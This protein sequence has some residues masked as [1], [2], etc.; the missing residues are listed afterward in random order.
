MSEISDSL[1][2]RP[3]VHWICSGAYLQGP[4]QLGERVTFIPL[5]P[6]GFEAPARL[7]AAYAAD[8]GAEVDSPGLTSLIEQGSQANPSVSIIVPVIHWE[9]PEEAELS[10]AD[11]IEK[12]RE[13]LSWA[14]GN[15]VNPIGCVTLG[16]DENQSFFRAIPSETIRRRRLGFGNTDSDFDSSLESIL[17]MSEGDE[18]VAFALSMLHDANKEKNVRFKIARYYTCLESLTYKIRKGQGSR[19]AV[20][21]LLGIEKGQTGQMKTSERTYNY[22]VVLG[23]GIL[24]DMLFHG[25]PVD[26]SKARDH[27]K[28]T[29][30]LLLDNPEVISSDLQNRVEL[31][32][33]RWSNG[34]SNG[35]VTAS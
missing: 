20:R 29:F 26:F 11:N 13:L 18:H 17:Q 31:E 9:T 25:V 16:P 30:E 10:V 2:I 14:T 24:R 21:Q 33:A 1:S 27:E 5:K 28:D 35:Q 6:F 23:A 4:I 34:A 12:Y 15:D 22:D 3:S 19:D 8:C 32:I 7:L